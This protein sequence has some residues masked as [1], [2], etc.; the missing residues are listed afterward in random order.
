MDLGFPDESG[1][2][3]GDQAVVGIPKYYMIVKYDLKGY[4]DQS[5]MQDKQHTLMDA[6]VEALDRD[7]VLNFKEFLVEELEITLL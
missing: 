4:S 2:M 1:G 7:I 5:E 6:Y 3:V